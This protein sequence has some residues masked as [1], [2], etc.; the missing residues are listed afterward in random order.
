MSHLGMVQVYSGG[1]L[2]RNGRPKIDRRVPQLPWP[3]GVREAGA[4]KDTSRG[5]EQSIAWMKHAILSF[6]FG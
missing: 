2:R 1:R 3:P 6:D 5:W 4:S